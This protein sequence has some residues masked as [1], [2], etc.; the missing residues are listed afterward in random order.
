MQIGR[1]TGLS[2][3]QGFSQPDMST[4]SFGLLASATEAKQLLD[5]GSN[6]AERFVPII[7][8]T[9]LA[10]ND[11][12]YEL[13]DV[14]VEGDPNL[15]AAG[16]RQ[17]SVSARCENQ[18]RQVASSVLLV[19]G[20]NRNRTANVGLTGPLYRVAIPDPATG[21]TSF[22]TGPA[23]FDVEGSA[24]PTLR[25]D[26]R[27]L[28]DR[29]QVKAGVTVA[30]TANITLSGTQ[31]V[32]GVSVSSNGTRVLVKNQSTKSQNGIYTKQTG[33]WTRA[34]DADGTTEL[35]YAQ[36]GVTSGTANGGTTW[37]NPNVITIGTTAYDWQQ[38]PAFGLRESD[39]GGPVSVVY[40][41]PLASWNNG[42]CTIT[43]GG[44]L[45]TGNR[46]AATGAVTIDN[47]LI[48]FSGG[49]MSMA[50][51]SPL[52][53]ETEEP[54]QVEL[55]LNILTFSGASVVT[56]T[57]DVVAIRYRLSG[58]VAGVADFSMAR[59]C[60]TMTVALSLATPSV[61]LVCGDGTGGGAMPD[62]NTAPLVTGG[63]G[64]L[65]GTLPTS[66][67]NGANDVD[68]NRWGLSY[69]GAMA[70]LTPASDAASR[71]H[72]FGI[73]AI[74]GGGTTY[75]G[76]DQLRGLSREWFAM[77]AQQTSAGVL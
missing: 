26:V 50:S 49:E 65:T 76:S 9:A 37:F 1:I 10:A 77:I 14:G 30:S 53:W 36:V 73:H 46:L 55:G 16:L 57:V 7:F 27:R 54:I 63:I 70:L 52:A 19:R 15:E 51:G 2:E 71:S 28:T 72:A 5:L 31:T 69:S 44:T 3:P 22:N 24:L 40:E 35:D 34:T 6:G 58:T 59:G 4:V 11:G 12:V 29:T 61:A 39:R 68:S 13:L 32:D 33:A 23:G 41:T 60:R 20:D 17:V 38:A 75:E 64:Y 66:A 47:G 42:A 43:Q 8:G 62:R 18:G 25:G 67:A 21:I 45:V 74:V 56:N 48:R